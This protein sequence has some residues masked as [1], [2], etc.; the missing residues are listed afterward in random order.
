MRIALVEPPTE[1]R[2]NQDIAHYSLVRECG[3]VARRRDFLSSMSLICNW[4]GHYAPA[5]RNSS[6]E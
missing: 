6:P 3:Q 4:D 2:H 5:D 1:L